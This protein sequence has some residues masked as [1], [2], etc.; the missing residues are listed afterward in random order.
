M[1]AGAPD[2]LGGPVGGVEMVIW[3]MQ[4]SLPASPTT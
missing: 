2:V 4:Q 3:R 1:A